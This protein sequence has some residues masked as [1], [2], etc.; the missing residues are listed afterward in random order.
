M[1]F[2]RANVPGHHSVPERAAGRA[3]VDA[4]VATTDH[5]AATGPRGRAV[6]LV[7]PAGVL[8]AS[9]REPRLGFGGAP[10]GNLF[11]SVES[12]AAAALVRHAFDRG[13]RYFD[14]APHYGNGLSE[15]RIS[16]GL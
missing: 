6:R 11:T 15:R 2:F 16:A 1:R 12:D 5:P 10:I 7:T 4:A 3:C 9:M 13:I 14:T 8:A